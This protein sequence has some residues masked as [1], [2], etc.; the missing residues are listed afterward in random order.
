MS[1]TIAHRLDSFVDENSGN[2]GV[3]ARGGGEVS[4][5]GNDPFLDFSITNITQRCKLLRMP[6]VHSHRPPPFIVPRFGFRLSALIKPNQRMRRRERF[7]HFLCVQSINIGTVSVRLYRLSAYDTT[8]LLSFRVGHFATSRP[9][10][11]Q[12]AKLSSKHQ[13]PHH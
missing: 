1:T 5:R 8:L 11:P 7:A 4:G 12:I 9:R 2:S 6:F 13:V 10:H 3:S